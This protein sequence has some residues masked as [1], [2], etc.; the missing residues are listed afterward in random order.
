MKILP[1][2]KLRLRAVINISQAPPHPGSTDKKCSPIALS[3]M[4]GEIAGLNLS[5]AGGWGGGE[6][7]RRLRSTVCCSFHFL[8]VIKYQALIA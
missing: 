1:C 7:S 4:G 3:R 2:P 5:G 6:G 8:D